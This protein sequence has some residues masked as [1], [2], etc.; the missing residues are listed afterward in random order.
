MNIEEALAFEQKIYNDI[1]N[2]GL[3][4]DMAYYILKSIFF[5]LQ[6]T[7]Y[8][9]ASQKTEEKTEEQII[10]VTNG[11]EG[12]IQNEQPITTDD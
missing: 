9:C 8:Q 4:V 10:K 7:L 12:E 6:K 11:E 5:D 3:P 1:N 2:C